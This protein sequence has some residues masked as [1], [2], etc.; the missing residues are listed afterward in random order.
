M[1]SKKKIW[2]LEDEPF[3][4]KVVKETLEF[5]NYEVI[6][7]ND[8][9]K[10]LEGLEDF[11]PDIC[12][13]DV[14]LPNEDGFTIGKKIREKFPRMPVIFLTAKNQVEDVVKGF[15]SGGTDYMRKPFSIEELIT[16]IE[17]QVK[18]HQS[19]NRVVKNE[20]VSIGKFSWSPKE[21]ELKINKRVIHLSHREAEVL[22]RL[23]AQSNEI[24]DRRKL[25]REV[26]GDDSF[27]NSRNLDVYI[28][29]L[30]DYFLEDA[31]I[32]IITLKGKGY[33]FVVNC[34]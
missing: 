5:R 33:R 2:Y 8:G 27:F 34:D 9:A 1:T 18:L 31:T 3:L 20:T 28:R 13:L 10:A 32:K 6:L 11:A 29:K 17:N 21:N 12:V 15:E 16:R 19:N 26:W 22:N 30:R 7:I 23:I 14:M 4:G 24:I 25:L